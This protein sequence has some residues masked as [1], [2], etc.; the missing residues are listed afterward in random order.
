MFICSESSVCPGGEPAQMGH[1][2]A[3][4]LGHVSFTCSQRAIPPVPQSSAQNSWPH[5]RRVVS[6]ELPRQSE[7]CVV[8]TPREARALEA[9]RTA[10]RL[11]APRGKQVPAH[12]HAAAVARGEEPL[13][14]RQTP[15]HP[16][17]PRE[18]W[19]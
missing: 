6:T 13:Q 15:P 10:P 9:V 4:Q 7:Q 19:E 3:L 14:L 11:I 17:V 1:A 12:A 18:L 2:K 8:P 16:H 5:T